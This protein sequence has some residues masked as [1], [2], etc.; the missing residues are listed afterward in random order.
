MANEVWGRNDMWSTK[1]WNIV[2]NPPDSCICCAFKFTTS[3]S[4]LKCQKKNRENQTTF[5]STETA[6]LYIELNSTVR[7]NTYD[8]ERERRRKR[9]RKRLINSKLLLFHFGFVLFAIKQASGCR[10]LP[11]QKQKRTTRVRPTGENWFPDMFCCCRFRNFLRFQFLSPFLR[12]VVDAMLWLLLF[13]FSILL[14]V[15]WLYSI[16]RYYIVIVVVR[17]WCTW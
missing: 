10:R 11:L 1:V 5:N 6:Y 14:S 13:L 9:Q 15:H 2:T 8:R 4:H 3:T 7:E 12:V 17:R 16:L